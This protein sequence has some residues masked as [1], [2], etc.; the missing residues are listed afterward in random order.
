MTE[1]PCR[2]FQAPIG[3]EQNV[4]LWEQLQFLLRWQADHSHLLWLLPPLSPMQLIS[5]N[6]ILPHYPTFTA[7]SRATGPFQDK[8][9]SLRMCMPKTTSME[10][11]IGLRVNISISSTIWSNTCNQHPCDLFHYYTVSR[12]LAFRGNH[13]VKV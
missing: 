7:L 10:K 5:M 4:L 11:A 2:F 1:V 9:K 13:C 6:Q 3:M 12:L 8:S